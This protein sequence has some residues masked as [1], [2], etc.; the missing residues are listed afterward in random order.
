MQERDQQLFDLKDRLMRKE[1]EIY[2]LQNKSATQD[3]QIANLKT[4][5]DRLLEVSQNL[6]ISMNKLEK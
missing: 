1:Q 5:R 2:V 6:R 3:S 4:E